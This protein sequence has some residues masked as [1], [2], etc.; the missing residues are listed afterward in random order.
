M[1]QDQQLKVDLSP[2]A[3]NR[4]LEQLLARTGRGREATIP[5][6]Q[7]LQREYR[8]LPEAVLQRVS[9]LTGL[10]LADLIG[11]ATFYHQFRLREAGRHSLRVCHGTACHVKGSEDIH[12]AI[13]RQLQIPEGSDTTPDKVFTVERVACA[14]QRK[15]GWFLGFRVNSG[16][17]HEKY[18]A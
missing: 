17:N 1:A 8:H 14:T 16:G 10:R 15:D 5:I 12:D 6:L 4:F 3:T 2:Q 18:L 7:G 11:V 9:E 13:L